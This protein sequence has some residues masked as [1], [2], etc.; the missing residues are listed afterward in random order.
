MKLVFLYGLPGVGKFTVGKELAKQTNLKLF[1]NHM[2]LNLII[3][4]FGRDND[5]IIKLREQMWLD[6]FRQA[7]TANIDGLIFTFCF[8]KYLSADFLQKIEEAINPYG[9]VH[10]VELTCSMDALK[11]RVPQSSRKKMYKIQDFDNL[12]RQISNGSFFVPKLQKTALRIDTTDLSPQQA[13]SLI[14][15]KVL[16]D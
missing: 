1:H 13:A 4:V 7:A 2:V 11:N 14:Y 12:M 6:F 15:R 8:D 10:Y 16:A 9:S 5:P 3:D